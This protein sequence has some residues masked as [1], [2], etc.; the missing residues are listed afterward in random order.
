MRVRLHNVGVIN[1]CDLE[2]IPGI[3]LIVGSSG[4][5][6]STLMRSIY[7]LVS[8]EFSDSDISFGKNTMHIRVDYNDNFVEYSRSLKAKGER[9]YYIVNNNQY[10]KLGRQP[11]QAV[12]DVLNIGDIEISGDSVNFNFNLQFSSPFLILGSQS[13]LYK[14][15]TYRST[16]DISSINDIYSADIKNNA[17]EISANYKLREQLENSLESLNDQAAAL[18]PVEKLYSNYTAYKHKSGIRDDIESLQRM[19]SNHCSV[20]STISLINDTANSINVAIDLFNK[21]NDLSNLNSIRSC[22]YSINDK[23]KSIDLID[24]KI[25]IASNI[26]E[27][28]TNLRHLLELMCKLNNIYYNLDAIN[29]AFECKSNIDV[30]IINDIVK[31]L[32]LFNEYNKCDKIV[33]IL[34]NKSD[35]AIRI[36]DDLM[37]LQL[38]LYD[39]HNVDSKLSEIENLHNDNNK[40]LSKFKVCPLCGSSIGEVCCNG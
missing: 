37:M 11:L 8:N 23:S 9:C 29:K 4:S 35:N 25:S 28:I 2:F 15:L 33:Q 6:K 26:I 18:Y 20:C 1:S 40:E 22:L 34:S 7:N 19:H 5:G 38:K 10:V 16:F 12:T 32:A 39:V 31:Q 24:N 27:T 36:V 3:N 30:Y 14:V 21:L 13:T 17:N